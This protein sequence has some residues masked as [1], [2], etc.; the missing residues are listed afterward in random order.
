MH[1]EQY[2]QCTSFVYGSHPIDA[3]EVKLEK[4]LELE[5]PQRIPASEPRKIRPG[6]D[7]CEHQSLAQQSKRMH[8]EQRCAREASVLGH[9]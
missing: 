8:L 6:V 7:Q 9:H 3:S 4:E 2:H 5:K 1:I